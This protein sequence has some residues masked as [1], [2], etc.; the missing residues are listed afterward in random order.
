M[1]FQRGSRG[2]GPGVGWSGYR[3]KE[4]LNKSIGGLDPATSR[5]VTV[6]RAPIPLH[7]STV[8][9]SLTGWLPRQKKRHSARS[10]RIH[11]PVILRPSVIAGLT[12]N[13]VILREVAESTLGPGP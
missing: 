12:R 7:R 3:I 10:R 11:A 1:K 6:Q 13:L 5:R 2:H 8:R 4:P 9:R